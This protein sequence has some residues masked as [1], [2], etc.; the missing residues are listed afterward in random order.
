VAE[1]GVKLVSGRSLVAVICSIRAMVG[2][3]RSCE[4]KFSLDFASEP[5][6]LHSGCIVYELLKRF[7]LGT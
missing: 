1:K 7:G 4:L 6:A 3:S 2:T 5:D